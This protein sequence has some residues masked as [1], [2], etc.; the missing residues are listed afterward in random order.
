MRALGGLG[1]ALVLAFK[2]AWGL[3]GVF[4][5]RKR[6]SS[7]RER[8]GGFDMKDGPLKEAEAT[9]A[10][11]TAKYNV[12]LEWG[13]DFAK[14]VGV[15]ISLFAIIEGYPPFLLERISGVKR[16]DARAILGVFRAASNR[17]DL[18]KEL[19]RLRPDNSPERILFTYYRGLLS[20]ANTLRNK[21]AHA[22][23]SLSYEP[24]SPQAPNRKMTFHLR[25][26]FSDFNRKEETLV[27]FI[28][29]FHKDRDRLKRI[30]C[31]LHA[32]IYRAEISLAL[33]KQLQKQAP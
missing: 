26:F 23:Y 4:S 32:L 14:A 10:S 1:L 33:H 17:L 13:D 3:G 2:S 6:T 9:I 27:H 19:V 7:S 8:A 18:I 22:Q 24:L 28:E 15:I 20:E 29:D 21:Y 11:E 31:E 16:D 5:I 30:I 25:T 12:A